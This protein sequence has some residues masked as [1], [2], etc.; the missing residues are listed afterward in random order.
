MTDQGNTKS[1]GL[2]WPREFAALKPLIEDQWGTTEDIYLIRQLS[3]GLSGAQVF[4]ADVTSEDFTGQAILKLD[5]AGDAE[6]IE[7]SEAVRHERAYSAEPLFS[8]RHLPRL[9]NSAHTEHSIAILS[10]VAARGLEFALPWNNVNHAQQ[11]DVLQNL[12]RALLDDWNAKAQM[13]RGLM[14]PQH[15]LRSWL[16]HRLDANKGRLH[17]TAEK[18]CG[19]SPLER[20]FT[21]EGRWLPNPLAFCL[22]DPEAHSNT[23]LRA[24][25]GHIHGDLHGL[26]VLVSQTGSSRNQYFMIDLAFY[27]QRQFLFYDHAYFALSLLMSRRE[28]VNDER[29]LSITDEL[30][31]F[32]HLHRASNVSSDD[33]GLTSLLKSIRTEVMGWVDRHQAH[34]LSYMEAQ[35]E[36]AQVAAGL[37]FANKRISPELRRRAFIYAAAILKDYIELHNVDWPKYGPP[38]NVTIP[39]MSEATSHTAAPTSPVEEPALVTNPKLTDGPSIAVLEF[40]NL[41]GQDDQRF[42]VQGLGDEVIT[43]LSRVDWLMVISR[44]SSFTYKSGK[45]DPKTVGRELGVHY[46]VEGTVLKSGERV[47]VSVKLVN[48]VSGNQ[49]WADRFDRHAVDVLDLQQEIATT[50]AARIDSELKR[51]ERESARNKSGDISRWEGLQRAMWH[52]YRRTDEDSKTA[53]DLLSHL[54]EG[55]AGASGA[56]A[57]M[58][59]LEMRDLLMGRAD[60]VDETLHNALHKA[61]QAVELDESSSLAR[62]ALSRV[63]SMQGKFDQ[64]VFEADNCIDLNPSSSVGYLNLAATLLWGGHAQDTLPAI[65]KSIRL[66]PKGP[67][68]NSKRLAKGYAYYYLDDIAAA[69]R[70]IMPTTYSRFLSP[71]ALL[72]KASI[73]VKDNRLEE[74]R[75]AMRDALAL[76][77][78]IAEDW[79]Q[80]YWR[81]LVPEY[82]DKLM[83]DLKR[84]GLPAGQS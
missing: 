29:W 67:M 23:R 34:R 7:K 18:I 2:A 15:L 28:S 72:L 36:L 1:D 21:I 78:D 61:R 44:G 13:A 73:F 6:E 48:A 52:F 55:G 71:F 27:E 25:E 14:A 63:Y 79:F 8:E 45:D 80:T 38:I 59:I 4:L 66:S 30:C 17:E 54:T 20:S 64:A 11:V 68:L 32:D 22:D 53:H 82:R 33:I 16:G 70:L 9:V 46:I 51:S 49:I 83:E 77:P 39:D 75:T 37:N 24:I 40:E 42:F 41:S 62:L 81:T 76:R 65:D 26:N 57:A 5:V 74:A 35:F 3:G 58:A 50:I 12:S 84:A 19:I 10:T 31:P 47:R 43:E 60:N 69:E 56:Y